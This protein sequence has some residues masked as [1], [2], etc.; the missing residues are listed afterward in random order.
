[1]ISLLIVDCRHSPARLQLVRLLARLSPRRDDHAILIVVSHSAI[2]PTV[3]YHC[4]PPLAPRVATSGA[5]ESV[6]PPGLADARGTAVRLTLH[7]QASPL[8]DA[9]YLEGSGIDSVVAGWMESRECKSMGHSH[10]PECQPDAVLERLCDEQF[11]GGCECGQ[12][13]IGF[14]WH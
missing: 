1:M 10:W 12:F 14:T 6:P 8:L 3:E 11:D 9:G 5:M 2:A 7:S 13:G 4:A